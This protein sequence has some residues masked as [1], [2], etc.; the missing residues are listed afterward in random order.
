MCML[1][2]SPNSRRVTR[3][4]TPLLAVIAIALSGCDTTTRSNQLG[5]PAPDFAVSDAGRTVHLS[6]YR[7]RIVVLNF[8]ATWCGPCREELPT[9]VALAQSH[10]ELT[11]LAVSADDNATAYANFLATHP[12]PGVVTVRDPSEHSDDLYGTNEF[13]ETFLIDRTG[14]LRRK[15][16][17]AQDW[18]SPELASYLAHL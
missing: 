5:K 13:P 16:I 10:P 3:L 12:M 15:F 1:P 18:T 11:I 4:L 6:D 7:G 9:L 14:I 8:W 17:G 2:S